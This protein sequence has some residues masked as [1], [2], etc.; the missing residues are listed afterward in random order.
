MQNKGNIF[1]SAFQIDLKTLNRLIDSLHPK[2]WEKWYYT[3]M[4]DQ[5]KPRYCLFHTYWQPF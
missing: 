3:W 4:Y 2:T 1:Y 5:W